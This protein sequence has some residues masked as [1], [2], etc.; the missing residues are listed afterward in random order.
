MQKAPTGNGTTRHYGT[1]RGALQGAKTPDAPTQP[2]IDW[3]IT[4]V[5]L[6]G[7]CTTTPTLGGVDAGRLFPLA[8]E[9]ACWELFP[10]SL[11]SSVAGQPTQPNPA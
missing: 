10:G 3:C 2:T 5:E 1:L 11:S 8:L 6:S 4:A 7:Y 9:A